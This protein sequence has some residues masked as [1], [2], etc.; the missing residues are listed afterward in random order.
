MCPSSPITFRSYSD[1]SDLMDDFEFVPEPP[2]PF[3]ALFSEVCHLMEMDM[4]WLKAEVHEEFELVIRYFRESIHRV[5][6]Y[7]DYR[8][9]FQACLNAVDPEGLI[10]VT[11]GPSESR[12]PAESDHA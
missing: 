8:D 11:S 9:L 7:L 2:D 10:R 12:Q 5:K 6:D 1:P 4:E 3:F